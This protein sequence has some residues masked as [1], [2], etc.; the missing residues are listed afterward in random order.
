MLPSSWITHLC[1]RR[2]KKLLVPIIKERMSERMYPGDRHDDHLDL[3]QYMI[4][5]AKGDDRQPERLAHLQL[6]VNLAGIHTTSLAITHAIHDLCEH[7]EYIKELRKEVEEVLEEDGG[8]HR[9]THNKLYKLDSFLKESQRFAPPT[10]C[11]S[12]FF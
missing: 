8:W 4:E 7:R 9:D 12:P 2:A 3:L 1:L 6:M 11:S 5:G 10:L